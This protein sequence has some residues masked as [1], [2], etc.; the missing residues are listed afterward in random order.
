[1]VFLKRNEERKEK[2]ELKGGQGGLLPILIFVSRPGPSCHNKVV[3]CS[4]PACAVAH[5]TG[6]SCEQQRARHTHVRV[7]YRDSASGHDE[8]E[9]LSRQKILVVI[10]CPQL[11]CRD[12]LPTAPLS[13]Q[14]LLG[15]VSRQDLGWDWVTRVATESL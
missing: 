9:G 11:L 2:L 15:P 3:Q 14:R 13:R 6:G 5:Q 1:M 12:R 7:H 10:D 8:V 4:A